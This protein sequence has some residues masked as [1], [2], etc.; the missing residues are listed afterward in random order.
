MAKNLFELDMGDG[1]ENWMQWMK[2]MIPN[3]KQRITQP[4][5][6]TTTKDLPKAKVPK[7]TKSSYHKMA[8]QI[9]GFNK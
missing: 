7:M 2:N 6:Y 5:S 8:R 4:R 3:I 1:G 9:L